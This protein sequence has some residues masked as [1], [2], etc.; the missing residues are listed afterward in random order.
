[1]GE[2]AGGLRAEGGGS[3]RLQVAVSA[4]GLRRRGPGPIVS[5]GMS[6]Q[7]GVTETS[8]EEAWAPGSCAVTV[9]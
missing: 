8:A 5:V 7:V 2:L 9:T 4:A 1:M 6:I 3:A